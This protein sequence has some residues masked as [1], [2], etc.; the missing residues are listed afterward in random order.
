MKTI[1]SVRVCDINPA[2]NLSLSLTPHRRPTGPPGPTVSPLTPYSYLGCY[3]QTGTPSGSSGRALPAYQNTYTTYG[4]S[5]CSATCM[6][7]NYIFFGTVNN[8]TAGGG[9]DCW[10]GNTLTYVT[11]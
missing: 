10:C 2:M 7:Q 4:N 8:S 1:R 9:A 6:G 3:V 11:R 5:K